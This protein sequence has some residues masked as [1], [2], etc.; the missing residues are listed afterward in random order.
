[1]LMTWEMI[2]VNES[3]LKQ[4]FEELAEIGAT[5]D[6][7]VNRLALS[8]EDLQARAWFA[9]RVDAA[10]LQLR[11]D[12]AGNLS[13][14]L[15]SDDPHA[16]TLILGSH[17]DTVPNGGKYDGS[18]GILAALECLRVIKEAGIALPFHLEA[19]DF[20]DEEGC[21]QSLFGSRGL[22]G[23]LDQNYANEKDVDYGPFRA[24][25]FRAGIRP[26]DA[27]KARRN[28]ESVAGYLELH[29]EQGFRLDRSNVDIGVVT[30]IVGRC[31]YEITFHGQA[32][33]SGTTDI[34]DRRD[35]LLGAAEFVTE[36]HR[37]WR[38]EFTDGM[39]NCGSINVSPGAFN[40]IPDKAILGVEF[41]HTDETIIDTWR[42][43]A[44]ELAEHVAQTHGLTVKH[45]LIK[46][47]PAAML[48]EP[49]VEVI[50]QACKSANLSYTRLISYAGHDAQTLST[51][52]PTGMIF[53]PSVG[54]I[55]HSPKEFTR[56]ESIVQGAN[57]LLQTVLLLAERY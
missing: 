4:D 18:V 47:M 1:M 56:W 43:R 31:N 57:A 39:F 25:L 16:K 24:A 30:G 42:D 45:R 50:E 28:P 23:K 19:I 34:H 51:F 22:T 20:T 32:S 9:D 33:H 14:V 52:T 15:F 35:A 7:G 53:I 3:R 10:G 40:I 48:P 46:H 11:D 26:M 37:L 8:N 17:M 49:L 2:G 41:R 5:V 54:G 38:T 12:D 55:S 13:G 36:A 27:H 29:I 44:V 21:W 6:G